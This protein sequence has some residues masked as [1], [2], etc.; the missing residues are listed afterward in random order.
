MSADPG[1]RRAQ[2]GP[3][4][5][6]LARPIT[7]EAFAPY[8]WVAQAEGQPGRPINGGS[9]LR[10]DFA[11]ELA[12]TAEHGSP[13]LTVFRAQAR[14]ITGP[15]HELERH[16]LGTQTFVPLA[17]VADRAHYVMLVA[18]GAQAPEPET[19]AA[20]V[21]HGAQAVTL[22]AGTWHHGLIALRVGDFVVIERGAARADCDLATLAQPIRL[23]LMG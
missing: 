6:V 10:I 21:V 4:S 13:C 9:S 2:G 16:R 17:A 12:L 7:A 18:L 5:T 23:R 20:F 22:H 1:A 15:W 3:V 8:G 14:E 19:L 11:G